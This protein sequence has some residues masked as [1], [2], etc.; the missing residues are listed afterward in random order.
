M[1]KFCT[2][3]TILLSGCASVST[4]VSIVWTSP[5]DMR[6]YCGDGA[7]ACARGKVI[8]APQP[9][10]FDDR[11]AFCLLGHELFHVLGATHSGR[12]ARC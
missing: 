5:S 2:V 9:K 1:G 7:V 3:L 11:K 8:Y 4:E 12:E 10:N 6:M